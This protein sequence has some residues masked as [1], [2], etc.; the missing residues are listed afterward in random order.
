MAKN[1]QAKY[2]KEE[3]FLSQFLDFNK[4][5][6]LTEKQIQLVETIEKNK[7]IIV[8]GPAGTSKT[9]SLCYTA[10]KL[11]KA[12]KTGKI[13]LCKPTVIIS[14]SIDLGA[15][16]GTLEEKTDVFAESFYHNFNQL[17]PS[18][19]LR[20]LK[21]TKV[22]EFKPVQYM[23]GCTFDNAV[24]LIDEFQNFHINELVT[25]ITRLG[26]NTKLV[27]AGDIR[28]NDIRTKFLAVKSLIQL[29]DGLKDV[30][31]FE[32]ERNDIMRD[33][34]LIEITDRFEKMQDEGNLP[35]SKND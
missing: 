20:M 29:V 2:M 23:R 13:I 5:V 26:K 7:I 15:L 28:Q 14:G 6:I 19:D 31:L 16:P 22:I 11:L 8:T 17:I 33:S 32:F 27:F 12:K 24:V 4:Q 34:I 10:I 18:Q 3:E 9:F 25:I 30:S 21:E 1:K 35:E